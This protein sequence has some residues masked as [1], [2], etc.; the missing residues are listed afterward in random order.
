MR[1]VRAPH[2][3]FLAAGLIARIQRRRNTARL[4]REG[5]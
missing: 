3:A 1:A 2:D 5:P 4:H